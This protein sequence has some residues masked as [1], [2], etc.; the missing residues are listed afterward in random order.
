MIAG[1]DRF[2]QK[3]RNIRLGILQY[4]GLGLDPVPEGMLQ[5]HTPQLMHVSPSGNR[6]RFVMDERYLELLHF[7]QFEEPGKDSFPRFIGGFE[8]N[9][10]IRFIFL[11]QDGQI[12]PDLVYVSAHLLHCLRFYLAVGI[13]RQIKQKSV[14]RSDP[15]TVS[16]LALEDLCEMSIQGLE[17]DL[18]IIRPLLSLFLADR[19]PEP[20]IGA[21]FTE[22]QIV[23]LRF[24]VEIHE[25]IV[26]LIV[27]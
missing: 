17:I 5:I 9:G 21:H 24:T 6:R 10:D 20:L 18:F 13:Q 14:R 3:L 16:L 25:L 1:S 23:D 22:D 19:L 7:V 4:M 26:D 27:L 8:H 15:E 12:I 2:F 11:R